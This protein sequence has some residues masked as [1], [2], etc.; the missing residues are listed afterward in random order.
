MRNGEILAESAH[1][2]AGHAHAEVGALSNA[3]PRSCRDAILYVSLEPC[4]HY[5]RT[6]PCT[7]L[8][9]EKGVQ[10]VVFGFGDPNPLVSGRGVE[11]LRQAGVSVTQLDLPEVHAFYKSYRHWTLNKRPFVTAKIAVSLDGKIAGH[12]GQPKKLTGESANR[13]T[14]QR[15]R[16][17]DC[18]LTSAQTILSDNP[19]LNA[20]L[21]GVVEPKP[22]VILDRLGRTPLGSQ[23]F[24]TASKVLLCVGPLVTPAQIENYRLL[25]AETIVFPES[26]NAL[27]L[28]KILVCLGEKG[29]HDLW[30]EAGGRL[31]SSFLNQSLAQ[32]AIVY[33]APVVVGPEGL[34]AFADSR[35]F[36]GSSVVWTAQGH[37]AMGEFTFHGVNES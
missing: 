4:C 1:W 13:L 21:D 26:Q 31:F 6:P 35:L 22:V 17:A 3:D 32:K 34:A 37:D 19:A 23:V 5:G 10:K 36:G 9:I 18:L 30:V 2:A 33:I 8:I 24:K 16:N 7:S 25:G 15:R 27:S 14:H 20:R 29:Y 12:K 11:I 28:D